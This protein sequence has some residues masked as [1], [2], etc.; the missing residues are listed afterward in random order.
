MPSAAAAAIADST[1]SLPTTGAS[2][3]TNTLSAPSDASTS[4]S[5]AM[6]PSPKLSFTGSC[7]WNDVTSGVLIGACLQ[8]VE[9]S[10][11]GV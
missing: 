2:T 7:V 3:T 8:A 11:R 5:S 10:L 6:A 4:D 1:P 9:R